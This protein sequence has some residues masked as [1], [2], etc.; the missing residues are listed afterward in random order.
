MIKHINVKPE[1]HKEVDKVRADEGLKTFDEA[2]KSLLAR[3]DFTRD[4]LLAIRYA[5]G[6]IDNPVRRDRPELIDGCK[7]ASMKAHDALNRL[8]QCAQER[9]NK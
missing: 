5:C 1:T 9:C 6:I 3:P 7:V 4:E 2:I 8:D